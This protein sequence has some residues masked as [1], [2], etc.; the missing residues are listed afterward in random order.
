MYDLRRWILLSGGLMRMRTTVLT[1]ATTLAWAVATSCGSD[2]SKCMGAEHC[3]CYGNGT[4]N[5]GLDC[6][7]RVCVN[8]NSTG[9]DGDASGSGVDTQ[10]CLSC[11][12]S[13]C[14]SQASD[15]KAASGCEDIIKCMIGCGKDAVCLSK[16]NANSS[17]DANTKSLTY[18]AC[19]FTRCADKC[20]Y[21]GSTG[22]GGSAG[23]GSGGSSGS[24][25]GGIGGFAGF[26]GLPGTG[27][28]GTVELTSGTNWLGILS[29]AA[30]PTMGPNGKLGINGVFY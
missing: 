6:R 21:S 10:A 25:A 22:A 23:T 15:C 17:P 26:A 20:L 7:S 19:A 8:L 29:D 13:N 30:P 9:F 2:D 24:A 5:A 12:E 3:A 16:C 28:S 1:A 4:C 27:G 11:A 18:Q 14:A